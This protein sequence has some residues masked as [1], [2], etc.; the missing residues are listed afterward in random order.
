MNNQKEEWYWIGNYTKNGIEQIH[1]QGKK[2]TITLQ[3][4]DYNNCSYL[5]KRGK[6]IY[7]VVEI[8]KDGEYPGGYVVAYREEGQ[9]LKFISM[10]K[11]E[12]AGP[13]FVT[14]DEKRNILYVANYTDGSLIAF[15]LLPDGT[16]GKK[17]YKKEYTKG[18]SH[19]HCIAFSENYDDVFVID[20]GMDTLYAYKIQYENEVLLLIETSKYVFPKGT[21]PRHMVLQNQKIYVVTERT[22]KLYVIQ[23]SKN[24]ELQK[25]KCLSLL[26]DKASVTKYD[27]GCAIKATQHGNY[28]YVSVRG[29]N[30]ISVFQNQNGRLTL[31]QEINCKGDIPRDIALNKEETKLLVANQ[32][33]NNIAVFQVNRENGQLQ[34]ECVLPIVEHPSCILQK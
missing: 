32:E 6:Y 13:C 1:L 26:G 28:F 20:L 3:N 16:I 4:K 25:R 10:Q 11:T 17:L 30:Q 8:L 12:G 24:Q 15:L 27:T 22:C 21:E 14:V 18:V 23:F 34:Y 19:L 33:S 31:I 9:H 7:S 29:K 5:Y 2:A